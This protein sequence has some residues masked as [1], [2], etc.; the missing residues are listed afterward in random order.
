MLSRADFQAKSGTCSQPLGVWKWPPQ[1]VPSG[2]G[3]QKDLLQAASNL[4]ILSWNSG[5]VP[6]H[7][8]A[9]IC[10]EAVWSRFKE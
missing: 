2:N 10:R 4:S 8:C 9:G 6:D 3:A 5:T 1:C 7:F